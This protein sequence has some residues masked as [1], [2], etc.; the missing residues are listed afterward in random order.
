MKNL[1]HISAGDF[2]NH[3]IRLNKIKLKK[4]PRK[5]SERF[6]PFY[7]LALDTV[8]ISINVHVKLLSD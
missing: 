4:T 7:L 5:T 1:L 2:Q 8:A 6:N 3:T